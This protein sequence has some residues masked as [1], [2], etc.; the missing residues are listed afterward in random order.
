MKTDIQ[1]CLD[2]YEWLDK[3]GNYK[4]VEQYEMTEN[5]DGDLG[6]KGYSAFCDWLTKLGRG[7]LVFEFQRLIQKR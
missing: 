1:T 7:D 4:Y 6:Q 5:P 3:T 2:F